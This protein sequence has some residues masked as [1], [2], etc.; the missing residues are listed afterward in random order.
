M[1]LM[2]LQAI[3]PKRKTS[4]PAP[5]HRHYPYLLRGL[6]ITRPCQVW[7]SDITYIPMRRGF[8]YLV[9]ILDWFSRYVLAWQLSNT[10]DGLFC[11]VALR[12][13]LEQEVP[14]ILNTDQGAQF[15]ADEFTGILEGAG[16]LISMDGHDRALDNIFRAPV[17]YGQ[18]RA[19]LPHRLCARPAPGSRTARLLPVLQ[20]GAP[21]SEPGLPNPGRGA[22]CLSHCWRLVAI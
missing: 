7:S 8:L 14:E 9:A 22:L 12:Q 6:Q 5:G 17:A 13:A 10:L 1:A 4:V 3:H 21:P 11:R 15:T 19:H 2:G 18:V 16:V 20:S